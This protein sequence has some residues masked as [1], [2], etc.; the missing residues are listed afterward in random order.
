MSNVRRPA[1]KTKEWHKL[2]I[3][4]G[5]TRLGSTRPWPFQ[6]AV[7]INFGGENPI[8]IAVYFRLI[9]AS[10]ELKPARLE[11]SVGAE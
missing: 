10:A 6:E 2:A 8:N 5:V 9:I 1:A 4:P 11:G 7:G 3:P